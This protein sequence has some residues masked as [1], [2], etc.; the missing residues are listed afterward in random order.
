[1]NSNYPSHESGQTI[2][3]MYLPDSLAIGQIVLGSR[4]NS[5]KSRRL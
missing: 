2:L 3:E 1:V 5:R 4:A